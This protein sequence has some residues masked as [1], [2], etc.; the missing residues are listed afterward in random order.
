M[1]KLSFLLA[2]ALAAAASF[3]AAADYNVTQSGTF[4]LT[5]DDSL[6][7]GNLQVKVLDSAPPDAIAVAVFTG[8]LKQFGFTRIGRGQYL[9][10]P[11]YSIQFQEF[12]LFNGT[13]YANV[14][15]YIA[16]TPTPAPT[17]TPEP[18]GDGSAVT[19]EPT[20]SDGSG[21]S[22]V[23]EQPL[24]DDNGYPVGALTA[25][26]AAQSPNCEG[27]SALNAIA[28]ISPQSVAQGDRVNALLQDAAADS[29]SIANATLR[30]IYP[31]GKEFEI[32]TDTLGLTSFIAVE[33]GRYTILPG[34][35]FQL[36]QTQV[37]AYPDAV[38]GLAKQA[39]PAPALE[40][41]IDNYFAILAIIVAI[42]L[43]TVAWFTYDFINE[44]T[45]LDEALEK[46]ENWLE[47]Q[48]AAL[49]IQLFGGKQ[50][51]KK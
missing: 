42:L 33:K 6:Y 44:N 10:L 17:A 5:V 1:R 15:V 40:F 30:V 4:L 22:G 45:S 25:E 39:I 41:F 2:F 18:T 13:N 27:A 19:P 50:E 35:C 14:S 21:T 26:Q 43:L 11:P 9:D 3:A 16:P 29:N 46:F 32:K 48:V 49:K 34:G 31:S 8:G 36:P 12:N 23:T 38:P 51:K 24:E 37:Y 7:M 20:P 47:T 28:A